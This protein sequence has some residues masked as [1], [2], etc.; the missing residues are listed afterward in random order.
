[1]IPLGPLSEFIAVESANSFATLSQSELA[2]RL[3]GEKATYLSLSLIINA[4]RYQM[5]VFSQ[6]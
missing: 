3:E 6:V 2:L 1:M 5:I 4:L